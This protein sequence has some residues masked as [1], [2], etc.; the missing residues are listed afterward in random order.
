MI[1]RTIAA[2]Q[3]EGNI[4]KV[5]LAR[6][7]D[8]EIID[9]G[10]VADSNAENGVSRPDTQQLFN[11]FYPSDPISYRLE[12]LI[13]PSMASMKPH[14]LP[15]TKK[16]LFGVVGSQGL[17]GI[18]TRVGQSVSGLFASLST[19]LSTNL[20]PA[21][22][23]ITS[24]EAQMMMKDNKLPE[25][26]AEATKKATKEKRNGTHSESQATEDGEALLANQSSQIATL[27]SRFQMSDERSEEVPKDPDS[28]G[29][30]RKTQKQRL[31]QRKVWALNRNG[32]V[33]FSIQE[34]VKPSIVFLSTTDHCRGALDFNPISTIASHIG[35]W[36]EEDV[37]HFMLS[38]VLSRAEKKLS[39]KSG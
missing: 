34:Y 15:Y 36:G 22:L 1:Q 25:I 27:Y 37:S 31:A 38:Q 5:G 26:S 20:L 28:D 14:N 29:K 10:F 24:D 4:S 3:V 9:D 12:P 6:A 39:G 2:R 19:G 33:D 30:D 13:A 8:S 11:I 23:R 32:R 18:G 21:S 17:T 16:G 7:I 35:Y